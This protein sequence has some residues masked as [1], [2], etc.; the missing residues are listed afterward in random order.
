MRSMLHERIAHACNAFGTDLIR[1][2]LIATATQLTTMNVAAEI[3][4]DAQTSVYKILC[5]DTDV[6][7]VFG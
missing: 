4:R 3:N 6:R 1:F 2:D 7:A 5:N